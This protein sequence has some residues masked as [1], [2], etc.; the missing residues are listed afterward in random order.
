[1][2]VFFIKPYIFYVG[3]I[4]AGNLLNVVEIKAR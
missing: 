1:M 3:Q 4:T 2:S